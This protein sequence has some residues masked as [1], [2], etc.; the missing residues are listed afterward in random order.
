MLITAILAISFLTACN[1]RRKAVEFTREGRTEIE[2][3]VRDTLIV[4]EK[5]DEKIRRDQIKTEEK[6]NDVSG[7]VEI[8]GK[9][10]SANAF[11]YDHIVDGDTLQSI[12]ISGNADFIIKSRNEKKESRSA[13]EVVSSS[14]DIV[15]KVARAVVAQDNIKAVASEI[16]KVEKTTVKKGFEFPVYFFGFLLLIIIFIV[17]F[18]WKKYGSGI[19][20]WI[21]DRKNRF[22]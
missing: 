16:K 17:W 22:G 5:K 1:N 19:S 15:A 9:T 21:N 20:K 18:L 8:K 12:S 11:K 4:E 14:L 3:I 13:S 10:D 2:K 6:K 7:E